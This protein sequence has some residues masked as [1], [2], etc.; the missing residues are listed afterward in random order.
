MPLPSLLRLP[1]KSAL[2]NISFGNLDGF[3]API[4]A[5]KSRAY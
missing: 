2:Q 5:A 3:H 1:D 4:M